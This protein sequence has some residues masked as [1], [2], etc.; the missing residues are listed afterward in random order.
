[1]AAER[2]L[3]VLDKVKERSA[4]GD[5]ECLRGEIQDFYTPS[6][7]RMLVDIGLQRCRSL[8]VLYY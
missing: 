5:L 6:K 1:M 7:S 2:I 3:T 8:W 4:I